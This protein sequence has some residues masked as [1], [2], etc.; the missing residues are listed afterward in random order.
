MNTPV[1]D[2][3]ITWVDSS[4]LLWRAEKEKYLHLGNSNTN[5]AIDASTERYRN[6]DNLHYWFR[7]VETYAPWV[8]KIHFITYGHLPKW[9]NTHHPKLHIVRHEDYIPAEYLPVFSSHPI[10]LFMHRIPGL[11]EQF[12][13]FNDDMFLTAPTKPEDFFVQGLPCDSISETSLASMGGDAVW[14]G[15]CRNNSDFMNRH[16]D[17]KICKKQHLTK[18]YSIKCPKDTIKNILYGCKSWERFHSLSFRHVTQAYLKSSF[19]T[20]WNLEPELLMQT[21]RH[22]FSSSTDVNHFI[23]R[24]YQLL[25]WQFHLHDMYRFGRAY[26]AQD[27]ELAAKAIRNQRYKVICI[28]DGDVADFLSIKEKINRAFDSILP[29]KSSYEK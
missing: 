11:S 6:W 24:E 16:F 10:E 4:D 26:Q 23:F 19:E 22:R 18:W 7:A 15:I 17:R 28:N 21:C 5:T 20:V 14:Q 3:V 8:N 12:V 27:L 29:Q 13:Y 2:F 25:S 1:I 9:L